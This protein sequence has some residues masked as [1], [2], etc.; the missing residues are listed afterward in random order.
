MKEF[1]LAGSTPKS[2][3]KKS[4]K[5][6]DHP[7]YKQDRSQIKSKRSRYE[8]TTWR[9]EIFKRDDYTCKLCGKRGVNLQA[10]HILPYCAYPKLR[11]DITN[12]RTLCIDCHKKTPTYAGKARVFLSHSNQVIK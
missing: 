4:H 10:D 3:L 5:G 2:N 6:E 7:N 12:G 1:S 11:F 9:R 8:L